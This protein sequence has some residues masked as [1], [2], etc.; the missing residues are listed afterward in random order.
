MRCAIPASE[1]RSPD[2]VANGV[3]ASGSA[4]VVLNERAAALLLEKMGGRVAR[5]EDLVGQE[6]R[7]GLGGPAVVKANTAP[8]FPNHAYDFQARVLDIVTQT[9][10]TIKFEGKE[11]VSQ[12]DQ[13]GIVFD[14]SKDDFNAP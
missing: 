6:L 5:I 4:G 13:P 9:K 12:S 3:C 2:T 7:G 10:P 11:C 8:F 1:R 14:H